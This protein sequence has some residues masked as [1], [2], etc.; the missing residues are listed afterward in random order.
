[1]ITIFI[2]VDYPD[3]WSVLT[4][5]D[6]PPGML[7]ISVRLSPRYSVGSHQVSN[8]TFCQ[9]CS[10]SDRCVG[11]YLGL[12]TMVRHPPGMFTI[13]FFDCRSTLESFDILLR[14]SV[15]CRS[16]FCHYHCF[17]TVTD[18]RVD[19]STEPLITLVLK[20]TLA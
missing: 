6:F 17:L 13:R 3:I 5:S 8:P 14:L 4:R 18:F 12:S 9:V 7:N 20:R 2:Q 10:L 11:R 15:Y 19:T 16:R 1:M